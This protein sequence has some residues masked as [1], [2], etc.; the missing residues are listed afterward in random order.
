VFDGI[1]I[2]GWV[3]LVPTFFVVTLWR[4]SVFQAHIL[5]LHKPVDGAECGIQHNLWE[6]LVFGGEE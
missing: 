2:F 4:Y 1:S 3:G 6:K 5:S